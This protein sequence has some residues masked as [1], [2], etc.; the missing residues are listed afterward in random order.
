MTCDLRLEICDLFS[1]SL[2]PLYLHRPSSERSG[3][4]SE[5]VFHPSFMQPATWSLSVIS[6]VFPVTP[7]ADGLPSSI[8]PFLALYNQQPGTSNQEPATSN[9][10]FNPQ[11]IIYACPQACFMSSV[12]FFA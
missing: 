8:C 6:S 4:P 9:F 11:C 3:R 7:E 12:D 5:A 2:F 10:Y 1:S